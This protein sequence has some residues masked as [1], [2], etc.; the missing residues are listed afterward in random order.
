MK[1]ITFSII[2]L[3]LLILV[4]SCD[5]NEKFGE[6]MKEDVK[7]SMFEF[8]SKYNEVVNNISNNSFEEESEDQTIFF[9]NELYCQNKVYSIAPSVLTNM[10]DI[11]R[12][13]NTEWVKSLEIKYP[14]VYNLEDTLKRNCIN[15][16]LFEN[17]ISYH[18]I[19]SN[20]DYINYTLNYK[21]MTCT[22]EMFSILFYGSVSDYHT[23]TRFAHAITFDVKNEQK[24]GLDKFITINDSFVEDNLFTNFTVVEN[25]FDNLEE[26]KSFVEKYV[27]SYNKEAHLNDFYVRNDEIGI[28][29][30]THNSMGYVT[31]EGKVD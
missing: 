27:L 4:I 8:V 15:K 12:P 11:K 29:I 6:Y 25:S 20:N 5:S 16:L 26:N 1:R 19:L 9:S 22:D 31:I 10:D 13:N 2:V 17:V 28:I 3:L 24:I 23:E 21:I 30:P 18:N 14:Q 7:E